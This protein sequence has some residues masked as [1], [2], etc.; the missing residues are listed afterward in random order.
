MGEFDVSPDEPLQGFGPKAFIELGKAGRHYRLGACISYHGK[1]RD[2]SDFF[3]HRCH[4]AF[5]HVLHSG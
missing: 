4:F 3:F 2:V 1:E 5:A